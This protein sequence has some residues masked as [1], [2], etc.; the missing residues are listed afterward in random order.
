[1]DRLDNLAFFIRIVEKRGVASA[2]RDF[3][4][5]AA[6]ASDRLAGLEAYYGATLLN[7]T[8]RS[9]SLT[10]AGRLVFERAK[11][12]VAEADD[13]ESQIRLGLSVL[14]GVI[15]LSTTVDLGESRIVPLVDEFMDLHPEIAVELQLSDGYVDLVGQGFD[16]AI[17]FGALKDSS[18]M[19]KKLGDN[20]RVI[21]AAP[22]YIDKHGV[23]QHPDDL[24]NHNCLIMQLGQ[25]VDREWPFR[26]G[27]QVCTVS[28]TGNR[29][30]NSGAL[31]RR[32][33]LA[34]RGIALKSIWD[35]REHLEDGSLVELLRDFAPHSES[36]LQILFP[37]AV[38]PVRRVRAFMEF[39]GERLS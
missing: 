37:R 30:A 24:V 32:W 21:C 31:V 14:S 29:L 34:G 17:R 1:M 18:L 8:T 7:R 9:I 15:R 10:D 5:S 26:I 33:C 39:L 11:L 12:L 38:Y 36:A 13:L 35:V 4:L 19:V 27:K 16:L 2:G 20:R 25:V 6:T 3:G 28:V 22:S 23:P